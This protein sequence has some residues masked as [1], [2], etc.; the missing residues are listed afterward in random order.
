MTT[1]FHRVDAEGNRY[2]EAPRGMTYFVPANC[3]KLDTSE[4]ERWLAQKL[5]EEACRLLNEA[6]VWNPNGGV[7]RR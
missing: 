5:R 2:Y 7:E 3:L 1:V 6:D 4:A